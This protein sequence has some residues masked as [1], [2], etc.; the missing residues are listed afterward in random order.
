MRTPRFRGSL[1]RSSIIAIVVLS[2]AAG[3]AAS[4][5]LRLRTDLRG[6]NE[7]PDADA[8]GRGSANLRLDVEGGE[9]C[10]T[11]DWNRIGTPNRAHIHVGGPEANGGIVVHFF[12]IQDN[13]VSQFDPLH[14]QLERRSTFRDC[15]AAD[16]AL[17]AQ[18]EANPGG[19]YVNVHN[20]RF[21]GGAIR[22][23][24]GD[25]GDDDD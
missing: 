14:D 15:V 11:I 9:V 20:A 24:L 3:V 8:D 23:Q 4:D 17:L 21:P 18:I 13:T 25:T 6:V 19:Y 5:A 22:G 10:V 7:N 16:P 1:V 12:N 2:L